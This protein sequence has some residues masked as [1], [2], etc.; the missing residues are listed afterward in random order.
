MMITHFLSLAGL[1]T[2]TVQEVDPSFFALKG[3][4]GTAA[5]GIHGINSV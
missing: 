5:E 1:N 4:S 2:R 3:G